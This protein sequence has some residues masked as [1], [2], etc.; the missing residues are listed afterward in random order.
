LQ[1][2]DPGACIRKWVRMEKDRLLIGDEPLPLNE[3]RRVFVLG[4]GKASAAMAA[5]VENLLGHRI[6]AGLIITKYG[7]G[8][9]LRH[10]RIMEAGHP[11]PDHNGVT[12]A[13]DLIDLVSTAGPEDLVLCLIS[14][15][16]SAL[17]PAPVQGISLE[18][19][20]AVTRLLLECGATI[21][22]INAIRKHLSRLKGGQLC[23]STQKARVVSLILSDV[24]G[25]DLD[26]IASGI[27]APDPDT[28]D[29]CRQILNQY[30]I[31]Q[32]VP[33]AVREHLDQG[34]SGQIQETP[35][36]GDPVFDTTLNIIVGSLDD[37]LTAAEEKARFLGF[38]PLRLTSMLQGEAREAARF[39]CSIIKEV[40]RSRKP[41]PCPACL[42]SGGETTVRIKGEG[43]GGRNME[44]A[45]AASLELSGLPQTM[46]L[47]AGTDGT[48]G[49]TDAAGAFAAGST[50]SRAKARGLSPKQYLERNDSYNFFKEI[51]ELFITG[52]TGTNVMD[53]QIMLVG[54]DWEYVP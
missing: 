8:R 7:H 1:A 18:D 24:I 42:L 29:R 26:I 48:D 53:M 28:F 5:E 2:V 27:T 40:H 34:C 45:L 4:I 51:D 9:F 12:A 43:L 13:R 32:S 37:A 30:G 23:R 6:H 50:A 16:G 44:L 10:C 47:S 31:L 39:L 35:K 21:Q 14:G 3:I 46:L 49:P 33:A 11:V 36:P 20:Q 22:E 19:K 52:P 25:D 54:N 41:V 38:H 17:S 15:G